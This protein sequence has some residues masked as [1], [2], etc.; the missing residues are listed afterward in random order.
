MVI[1]LFLALVSLF[2]T[3]CYRIFSLTPTFLWITTILSLCGAAFWFFQEHAKKDRST[4]SFGTFFAHGIS[5]LVP[6]A[7]CAPFIHGAIAAATLATTQSP[8]DIFS[9]AH[10][11]WLAIA[12][13]TTF[14]LPK[15]ALAAGVV[16]LCALS[17][18]PLLYPLGFGFDPFI[19]RAS[20]EY[21]A[22]HGVIT[23]K[24]FYYIGEYSIALFGTSLL[25]IPLFLFDTWLAPVLTGMLVTIGIQRK[26]FSPLILPLFPL[27]LFIQTTPQA[28][29]YIFTLA[30]LFLPHIAKDT[31]LQFNKKQLL[32]TLIFALAALACHPIAGIPA[33]LFAVLQGIHLAPQ[34]RGRTVATIVVFIGTCVA[35]PLA[36]LLFSI[37]GGNDVGFSLSS[38]QPI[39]LEAF[40]GTYFTASIDIAYVIIKNTWL[41]IV[42]LALYGWH[43]S[44]PTERSEITPSLIVA[45]ACFVNFL[46]LSAFFSFPFLP[47]YER[48]DFAL[49]LFWL[50]QL[51]LLPSAQRGAIHLYHT[52]TTIRSYQYIAIPCLALTLSA[53]VYGAYPRH[54][55]ATRGGAYSVSATDKEMVQDI[56]KKSRGESY[57]V[58]ADQTL[59]SAA[60][61]VY[62][63][64]TYFHNNVFFYPIPTGGPLYQLYLEAAEGGDVRDI[65]AHAK[66]LT[67]AKHVY[68]AMH[69]YWWN[70]AVII[71]NAKNIGPEW[72][73]VE[74]NTLCVFGPY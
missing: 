1:F 38:W 9:P 2:G 62:G 44:T 33:F 58:L 74:D 41:I 55:I 67:G 64:K 5:F 30:A 26:R 29:A 51:F 73:C 10:I 61:S 47:A 68:F 49:R 52:I 23:P 32:I 8:W 22:T 34:T 12:Y 35:V 36:F 43:K 69:R 24:T 20:I 63:F 28:L 50:T 37:A 66:A 70:S 60:I 25:H 46:L 42:L 11:I 56:E 4:L 39:P 7:C 6:A 54:D 14:F 57:V 48:T 19:H 45:I 40:W 53:Q 17:L 3:L 16:T 13:S 27:A 72:W 65:I 59:S 18:I 71:E 15:K 21:I 31:S